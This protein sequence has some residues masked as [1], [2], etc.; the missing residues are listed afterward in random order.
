MKWPTAPEE[1]Q[2]TIQSEAFRADALWLK[3]LMR[4][5]PQKPGLI[6]QAKTILADR[7]G[8]ELA[9]ALVEWEEA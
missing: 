7:Y 3:N 9:A 6:E 4:A 2:A 1:V 5:M 8:P